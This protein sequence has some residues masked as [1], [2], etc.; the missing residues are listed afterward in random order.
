MIH[1]VGTDILSRARCGAPDADDPFIRRAYTA[2][3]RAEAAW[4]S[5]TRRTGKGS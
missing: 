5:N 3:E 1:G 4:S 2:A